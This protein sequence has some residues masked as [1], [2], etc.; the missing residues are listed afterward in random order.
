MGTKIMMQS[1]KTYVISAGMM[2]AVVMALFP[3]SAF[4]MAQEG[5]PAAEFKQ[6][7][8]N[9][10]GDVIISPKRAARFAHFQP[11]KVI[12]VDCRSAKTFAEGSVPNAQNI[13]AEKVLN[14]KWT[15]EQIILLVGN[16]S[17]EVANLVY[18]LRSDKNVRAFAVAG[19]FA[20]VKEYLLDPISIKVNAEFS[21]AEL[22]DLK[23]YRSSL[24]GE[25]YKP[26][27]LPNKKV[28]VQKPVAKPVVKKVVT[29]KKPKP[30]VRVEEEEE[31]EEEEGC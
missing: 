7:H 15:P 10:V 11:D 3:N 26:E 27:A 4:L 20:S 14:T 13:K 12:W 8:S 2:L 21:T 29:K 24:T 23:L 18:Q 28:T 6:Q 25:E 5:Y 9:P 22:N 16:D 17:K 19:G 30:P 1:W 31:E